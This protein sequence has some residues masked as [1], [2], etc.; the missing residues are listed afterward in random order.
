MAS[1]GSGSS[2][3]SGPDAGPDTEPDTEIHHASGRAP[4]APVVSAAWPAQVVCFCVGA[5]EYGLDIMRV[6]EVINPVAITRMPDAPAF[7]EGVIDLRGVF[8]GV[9]DLRRRLAPG[10]PPGRAGSPGQDA[11]PPGT[12]EAAPVTSQ[13]KYVIARIDADRRLGLVVDRVTEVRRLAPATVSPAPEGAQGCIA[14]LA[15]HEGGVIL[16]LDLDRLLAPEER[17]ALALAWSPGA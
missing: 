14:G 5:Q 9:M 13:H 4:G 6:K 2:G 11:A 16:L 1:S 12:G 10:R 17:A 15:R 7:L 3:D 8:L